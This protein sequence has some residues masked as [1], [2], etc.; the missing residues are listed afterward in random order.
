MSVIITIILVIIIVLMS[1]KQSV[2]LEITKGF[3]I[4]CDTTE[5]I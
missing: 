4:L 5:K 3:N 2:H 1:L